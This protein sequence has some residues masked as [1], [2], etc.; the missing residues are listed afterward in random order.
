MK[1]GYRHT[2]YA[3]YTGY[4]SQAI[5]INLLPLLFVVLQKE[6]DLTVTQICTAKL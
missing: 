5:T 3:C 6:Y 2:L 1:L 4:I